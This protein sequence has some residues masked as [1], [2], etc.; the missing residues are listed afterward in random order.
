[1]RK[2]FSKDIFLHEHDSWSKFEDGE[3]IIR[4]DLGPEDLAILNELKEKYQIKY[5]FN[6]YGELGI[7]SNEHV[8]SVKLENINH[9]INIVPKIF[10]GKDETPWSDLS[11]LLAFANDTGIEKRLDGRKNFFTEDESQNLVNP[12][13][14]TLIS[15]CEELMRYGLLKSY[16][17]HAEN[18]SGLRGKLLMQ[19]Q[20]LNDAMRRP[21][22]FCEYDELEF[23]STENRLVLQA[24]TIVE[25]ISQNPKVKMNAMYLAQRLSTVVKKEDIRRR[26][27]QRMMHSYNRQNDRYQAIHETCELIIEQQGVGNIYRGDKSIVPIFYDMNE[28]FELFVGNLFK[29]YYTDEEGVRCENC[30]AT[31]IQEKAW[32]GEGLPDRGMRPDIVIREGGK[33]KEII[34]VKYKTKKI[35]TVDLYQ[36]G[37][38]MHEY[39]NYASLQH[40][41]AILPKVSGVKEGSYTATKTRK[42]VYVKTVDVKDCVKKIRRQ[43]RKARKDLERI[44]RDL[45]TIKN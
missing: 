19:Y 36:I 16:V 15:R 21:K 4:A 27:R 24:M 44:V 18:T 30:V 3:K 23:D 28:S 33:V 17:V 41:F 40:A 29:K 42:T 39:G 26:E 13:H 7:E 31:Q 25:R 12:L 35:T 43:D 10:E 37:F 2:L 34:D 9:T 20:M 6:E 38:Y 5:S 1:M 11:I 14:W 8:G 45:I 32:I 22:F